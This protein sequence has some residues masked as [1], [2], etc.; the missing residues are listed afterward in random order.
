M[1]YYDELWFLINTVHQVFMKNSAAAGLCVFIELGSCLLAF[2]V[3]RTVNVL[4]SID[5][6]HIV[7]QLA[8]HLSG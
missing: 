3:P 5:S 4:V 8:Q 2:E 1:T 7:C 6:L